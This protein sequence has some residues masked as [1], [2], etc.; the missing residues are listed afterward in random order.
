MLGKTPAE[1]KMSIF[2]VVLL[3]FMHESIYYEQAPLLYHLI[4]WAIPYLHL[5]S[6][7]VGGAVQSVWDLL[8]VC[9]VIPDDQKQESASF[10]VH[11]CH[12]L[13]PAADDLFGPGLH[14]TSDVGVQF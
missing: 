9:G 12:D 3:S 14:D 4:S 2:E 10:A 7:S 11:W 1:H 13:L 6:R 5:P 8:S